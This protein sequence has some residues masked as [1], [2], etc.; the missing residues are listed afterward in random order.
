MSRTDL[1]VIAGP[2]RHRGACAES[3]IGPADKK[4]LGAADINLKRCQHKP[5]LHHPAPTIN[6]SYTWLPD[7]TATYTQTFCFNPPTA[8]VHHHKSLKA[9]KDLRVAELGR[10]PGTA[11][12]VVVVVVVACAFACALLL[13]LL[14][15]LMLL[16]LL[17]L[18]LCLLPVFWPDHGICSPVSSRSSRHR[19]AASSHAAC[20]SL[21]QS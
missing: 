11:C 3:N 9:L 16:L 15:L 4:V 2:S 17:L 5:K 20:L 18:M 19:R 13:L 10:L 1:R 21:H 7:P 14:L 12:V 6:P 8:N